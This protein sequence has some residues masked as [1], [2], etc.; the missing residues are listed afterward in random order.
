M[1]P[2]QAQQLKMRGQALSFIFTGKEH[3]GFKTLLLKKAKSISASISEISF[4]SLS[5]I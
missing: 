4:K 3:I 5:I 1:L 2:T